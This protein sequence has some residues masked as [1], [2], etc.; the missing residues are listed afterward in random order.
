MLKILKHGIKENGKY[1][2]CYY[3]QSML[4]GF[5]EGTITIYARGY[6][7]LPASLNPKNDTDAMTDYFEKDRARITPDNPLHAEL[8]KQIERRIK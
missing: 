5:P 3:S 4:I 6:D 8:V 1:H 2:P 7:S